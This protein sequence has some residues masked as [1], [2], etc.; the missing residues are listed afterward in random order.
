MKP[1]KNLII[2]FLILFYLVVIQRIIT[3]FFFQNVGINN[4]LSQVQ[5]ET[6]P[7]MVIIKVAL[8]LIALSMILV[9]GVLK[10]NLV[11]DDSTIPKD[12]FTF[13][14]LILSAVVPTVALLNIF[15]TGD[16]LFSSLLLIYGIAF[17]T[18]IYVVE[19]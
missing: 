18:A 13:L 6:L 11:T 4:A 9:F 2:V 3:L 7:Y 19:N 12:V 10:K 8:L 16:V 14:I 5:Q 1:N 17:T 15:L